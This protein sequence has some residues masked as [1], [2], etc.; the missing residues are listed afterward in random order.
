MDAW[1][2][3]AYAVYTTNR[4]RAAPDVHTI[5]KHIVCRVLCAK[6]V[7]ATSSEGFL[8]AHI[9]IFLVMMATRFPDRVDSGSPIHPLLSPSL[10]FRPG[11]NCRT[12]GSI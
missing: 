3:A 12:Q 7:G 4:Q 11:D 1:Y 5:L 8:V 6:V 10:R 9:F 2:E